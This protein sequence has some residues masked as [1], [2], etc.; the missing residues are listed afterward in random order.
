MPAVGLLGISVALSII[1]SFAGLLVAST[2]LL[3]RDSFRVQLVN[4]LVSYA[5]PQGPGPGRV[6]LPLP[7]PCLSRGCGRGGAGAPRRMST[8]STTR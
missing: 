5:Y 6:I 3:F 4:W 1:G 8:A 2:I 7:W